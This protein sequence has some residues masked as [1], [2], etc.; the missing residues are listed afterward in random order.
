MNSMVPFNPDSAM[1]ISEEINKLQQLHNSGA[2]TAQEFAAAKA[3]VLAAAN[4]PGTANDLER[5]K[6]ENELARLDR[7]WDF[8]R[9]KYMM[10][11]NRG[12]RYIPTRSAASSM[13]LCSSEPASS[14]S[15]SH[16]R[17]SAARAAV[18]CSAPSPTSPSSD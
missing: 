10:S 16:R 4:T 3:A 15:S 12:R 17:C 1:S 9:D 2:M 8:D 11:R 7:D 13:V 5:M 18:E 14:G 6:I